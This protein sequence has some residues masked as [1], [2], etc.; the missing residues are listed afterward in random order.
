MK[1]IP[2]IRC[3]TCICMPCIMRDMTLEQYLRSKGITDAAFGASAGLSQ[4]QVSRIKRGVS[5]PSW[6]AIAKIMKATDGDVTANDFAAA[7][8]SAQ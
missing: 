3:S 4:A 2:C 7:V 5:M 8:E 6:D 1:S